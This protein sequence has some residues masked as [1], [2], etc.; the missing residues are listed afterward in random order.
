MVETIG[1]R[2][3]A[4][5]PAASWVASATFAL[6]AMLGG[7]L[8]FGGLAVLGDALAHG[9][10]ALREALAAVI[11]VAAAIAD[12]RGTRIAPQIRRQVPERWRRSTPL[13]LACALYGVLLGLAFT[14]FVL[15]FAV[16]ALA[17]IS[18]AA[19]QPQL[20]AAVG[21]AFGLGRAL[22]VLV[23]AP[24]YDGEGR[25]AGRLDAMA[26]EPRMWLGLR[27][28]DA[29]GLGACALLLSTA[30]AGAAVLRDATDP[31]AARGAL[32]WQRPGGVA[33]LRQRS[34]RTIVLPGSAPA[35]G[36]RRVAWQ[37]EGA[38]VVADAATLV[39]VARVQVAGVS[40]QLGVNAV[41]V[42][43]EW[44]V[45][46]ATTSAGGEA[47]MAFSLLAPGTP[48]AI[49]GAPRPGELG[50]PALSGAKVVFSDSTQRRSAIVLRD[51]ATGGRA[52]LRVARRGVG[53][54]YPS[55]LSGRLLYE[56]MT[57]CA[58]QLRLGPLRAHGRER[59]LLSLSST[60]SR[61]PGYQ[62][63]YEHA[64]NS[65]S[66]CPNR[67]TGRG[68]GLRLGPTAL[69]PRSAFVTVIRRRSN[70]PRIRALRR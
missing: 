51:L 29:L 41:A 4:Q 39:P 6:G 31:S 19:G 26:G 30:S 38:I 55:L 45:Y 2:L 36:G 32:A 68:S 28:L 54:L 52:T 27:R 37:R 22:P 15:A 49:A 69:G 10:G 8:T 21:L 64:Y 40:A 14:T 18:F 48:R 67:G 43:D 56:R 50:R 5:R 11:A 57:R 63:G 12:W 33:E 47:L 35:L 53:L 23:M 9:N 25:G 66:L 44:V 58:Q 70:S 62:R 1:S 59:V 17:G 42:S 60:A 7:L 20:G 24:R 34:G 13:P 65:A 3:G 46:R 61:D 16:W